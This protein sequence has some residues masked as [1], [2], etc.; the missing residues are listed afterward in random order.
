MQLKS[1][2]IISIALVLTE[3]K[4]LGISKSD[5]CPGDEGSGSNPKEWCPRVHTCH[6]CMATQGC[7][8]DGIK[9]S[10]CREMKHRK[11][12]PSHSSHNDSLGVSSKLEKKTS[13][14]SELVT[15]NPPTCSLACSER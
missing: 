10:N 11:L 13:T 4:Y 6:T 2:L 3:F 14:L 5:L 12:I 9:Q 1:Y 8:W 15:A 7:E